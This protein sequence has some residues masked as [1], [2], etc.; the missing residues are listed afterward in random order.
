MEL[1]SKV[2]PL[3]LLCMAL[4]ISSRVLDQYLLIHSA[5]ETHLKL[6]WQLS[7]IN[8]QWIRFGDPGSSRTLEEGLGPWEV[9]WV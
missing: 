8:S 9:T 2:S 6:L 7:S 4:I 5:A 3:T 1:S